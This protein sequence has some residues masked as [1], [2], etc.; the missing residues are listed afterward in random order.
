MHI[1]IW[2]VG[3]ENEPFIEEGI[4]YY[5][6]KITPWNTIELALLQ[7]SKK[8]ATTDVDKTKKQEEELILKRL[9]AQHYLILLDE[10]GTLLSSPQW[11]QQM[12]QCMNTGVRTLVL[13]IGGAYGVSDEVRKQARQCWSLSSLVFP[14]QLVRLI[15]TEQVYRALSILNHSPYHHS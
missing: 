13:L 4:H 10:R 5:F 7:P 9:T 8:T 11:A 15:V 2:S 6:K 3:K 12:Q 14:H 1:Q